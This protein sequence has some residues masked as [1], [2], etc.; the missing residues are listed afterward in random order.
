MRKLDTDT[1]DMAAHYYAGL[2]ILDRKPW[3]RGRILQEYFNFLYMDEFD[4]MVARTL[5]LLGPSVKSD[6]KKRSADV[7][8]PRD[9]AV[10][11]DLLRDNLAI[12]PDGEHLEGIIGRVEVGSRL[13]GTRTVEV[14]PAE[15]VRLRRRLGLGEEHRRIIRVEAPEY[16]PIYAGE[17]EERLAGSDVP[18]P[19]P[20]GCPGMPVGAFNTRISNARA[21]A[22]CDSVVDALDGGTGNAVGQG[23]SGAQ[24]AT[25]DDVATGTL[26][27]TL[28][29]SKPAFGNAVD[30][31][32]GARATANAITP[33]ASADAT[34]T[35]GYVRTSSSNDSITPLLNILDGEAGVSGADFNFN[36]V[37]VVAG[38]TVTL[39]SHT[40]TMPEL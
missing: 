38:A 3:T 1:L 30:I 35:L 27:F 34:G 40:V 29:Y 6:W 37:S 32:P 24:P 21:I 13:V 23:R 31:N 11:A 12:G 15:N 9:E 26:L 8:K 39:T 2:Y 19:L 22:A 18:D 14:E 36:T 25:V 33:D 5:K 7:F 16:W 4:Y 17:T 20:E 10:F 28:V